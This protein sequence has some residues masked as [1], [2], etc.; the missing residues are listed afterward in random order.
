MCIRDRYKTSKEKPFDIYY[1]DFDLNGKKDIVLGYYN[2]N[3]HYPLRGFSCSAQQIPDLKDKIKKYDV[4]AAL[5]IDQVYGDDNLDNSLHYKAKTFASSYVENLGNGNFKLSSLPFKAQLSNINDIL[6]DDF[7]E[8]GNLD[9]VTIGNLFVSEIETPR[10]D[11][12]NGL[13]MY[14]NG[15]GS[16]E[17]STVQQLSLIHISEPTRPY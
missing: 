14:G 13:L 5:E 16:F 7:N 17:V 1:N 15:N 9:L 2:N 3:K 6:V 10:N 4:F 11:A 12:G 8:D